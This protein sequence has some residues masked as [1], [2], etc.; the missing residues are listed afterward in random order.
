MSPSM[1]TTHP[2]V[3][4]AILPTSDDDR[5]RLWRGLQALGAEA[6]A[7]RAY[8]DRDGR[9][10]IAGMGELHLHIVI[11]RL[12]RE[13]GV[14]TVF[15]RPEVAYRQTVGSDADGEGRYTSLE[16]GGRV[17]AHVSLHISPV[18]AGTGY[19][20]ATHAGRTFSDAVSREVDAGIRQA[21]ASGVADRPIDDICVEL[22][23]ASLEEPAGGL[24]DALRRAAAMAFRNAFVKAHLALVEPVMRVEVTVPEEFAAEVMGDLA[25]RGARWEHDEL[26]AAT[27]V[28]AIRAAMSDLLGYPDELRRRTNGRGGCT[29]RVDGYRPVER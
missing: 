3:A 14:D 22:R 20:F 10:W 21:M 1:N 29:M 24:G 28:I 9:T 4:T 5:E 2:V 7:I 13:F 27:R 15:R 16:T 19:V 12:R 23:D 18:A 8:T 26:R 6:P 25:R 11:D 17:Y